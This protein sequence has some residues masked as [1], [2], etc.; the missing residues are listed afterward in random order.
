MGKSLVDNFSLEL[1]GQ[2]T[3]LPF[4]SYISSI[5]PTTA[6]VGVLIGGSQNTYKSLLGTVR[7]RWGLKRRGPADATAAGVIRSY[8]WETSL[9]QTRVL[10]AVNGTLQVEIMNGSTIGYSDLISGLTDDELDFSFTPWYS[11]DLAKDLLIFVNGEQQLNMWPGGIALISAAANTA[12]IIFQTFGPNYTPAIGSVYGASGGGIGYVVGDILTVSGGNGDAQVKVDGITAATAVATVTIQSAGS[13]YTLG[14]YVKIGSVSGTYAILKITGVDGSGD[15]TSV[16]IQSNGLGYA[17]ASAQSTTALSATGTGL[18]VNITAVGTTIAAWHFHNNGSGYSTGTNVAL[19]GGTGTGATI[20]ISSVTSGRVSVSGPET[21]LQLG[22]PGTLNP[23]SS[24]GVTGGTF[25]VNGTSY[26]YASLGDDYLSF[27]GVSPDPTGLAG[28]SAIAGITVTDT[29]A[30]ST[31]NPAT[32]NGVVYYQSRLEDSFTNDAIAIVNN[33]IQLICYS[34]RLIHVSSDLNYT[35]F[36]VDYLATGVL[37]APGFPDILTLDSNGRAVSARDGNAVVFGSLGDSYLVTRIASTYNQTAL[38]G[39]V[40]AFAYEQVTVQKQLSSDLS[41]PLGQNFVSSLNDSIIYLDQNNQLRQ[42]GTLRNLATPVY[43]IFSLDVY[44]ELAGVDFTG[45]MLRVVGEQSGESVYITAPLSGTLYIYQVRFQIDEVGNMTAARLWQP[46]FILGCSTVAVIDG[47]TYIYS[48]SNPQMYQV[49]DTGQYSDDSPSDEPIPYECHAI[50]AYFSLPDRAQQLFFDKLYYE[51]Y[52]TRGTNLYN[53]IYQEY[54]GAKN[55]V[56]VTVNKAVN[57]GK[58]S[59]TFYD[60]TATPSLGDVSLGQVPLGEG[61]TARGGA[62]TPKFRALR[63]TQA[64]DMFEFAL[65]LASYD[66]D[67]NWQLLTL[68]VNIQST[69]RRPTGIMA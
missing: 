41:S 63:R 69:P 35:H 66:L 13:G 6:G 49:W 21:L 53:N 48:N 29:S 2:G 11:Q 16:S 33:Q 4:R 47:I 34:S 30:T 65:D 52:M 37:R 7:N 59:A 56:T 58:R 40:S 25:T 60:S 19:T 50:F 26:S 64:V 24:A 68:G 27:I 57:P 22:F 31:D 10:R 46:P 12:G 36:D 67:C 62:Q 54:Q 42:Y 23:T 3:K 5:D 32:I 8:E 51:G 39:T 17:V 14:D 38:D 1:F 20:A 45:G 28:N 9:G 55:I 43:P 18:T 44:T 15:V 61:V